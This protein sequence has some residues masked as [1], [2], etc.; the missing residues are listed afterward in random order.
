MGGI[1]GVNV[2][3]AV[4]GRLMT[5]SGRSSF[6]PMRFQ[7]TLRLEDLVVEPGRWPSDP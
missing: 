2:I 3:A 7:F 6:L 4:G 1:P 5:S